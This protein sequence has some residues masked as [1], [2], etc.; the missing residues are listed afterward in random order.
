[1]I[2]G[3]V[4]SVLLLL[5]S[6]HRHKAGRKTARAKETSGKDSFD[7]K[8]TV[9]DDLVEAEKFSD[10][11]C[12]VWAVS[13][14]TLSKTRK[15]GARFQDARARELSARLGKRSHPVIQVQTCCG[16]RAL[17]VNPPATV[18]HAKAD[19]PCEQAM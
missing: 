4:V 14:V 5:L 11:A 1:M 9:G 15:W 8:Q 3:L 7:A 12:L 19:C 10:A 13:L 16:N 6:I 17:G 18:L 2:V